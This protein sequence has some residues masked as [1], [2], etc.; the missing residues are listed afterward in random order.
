MLFSPGLAIIAADP[1]PASLILGAGQGRATPRRQGFV[2]SGGG[3]VDVSQ[4]SPDTLV[5][6]MTGVAVAGAHP[7]KDSCA[8]WNFD[9][10]QCFEIGVGKPGVQ[11][12][13]LTMDGRVIGLLRS[14]GRGGSASEGPGRAAVRSGA[15]EIVDLTLPMHCAANG[16]NVSLNDR[17]GPQTVIVGPG[18][19]SL[20]QTWSVSAT[21]PKCLL[22]CKCASG[23]FA[24]EPALDPLWI[25]A[26]EPFKGA[27][28]KDFGFQV[29]VKVAIDELMG[30]HQ[31]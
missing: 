31:P 30:A 14:H 26:W 24:P 22:P 23:E 17:S 27:T 2:H 13:R 4:P 29:I 11:R 19:Y 20:H 10:A 1:P 8:S 3:N 6:T 12:V 9:F 21:H 28:K 5:V 16:E 15:F 7:C 25:S 18:S